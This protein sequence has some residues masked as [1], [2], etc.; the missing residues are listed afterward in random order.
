MTEKPPNEI[1][2]EQIEAPAAPGKAAAY[3]QP[4]ENSKREHISAATV[5]VTPVKVINL[6]QSREKK[7]T[8]PQTAMH[9]IEADEIASVM[10]LSTPI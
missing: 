8:V 10:T 6:S 9:L 4:P 1:A 3:R 5:P 7:T 2:K